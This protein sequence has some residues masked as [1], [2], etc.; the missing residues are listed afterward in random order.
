M[1]KVHSDEKAKQ[2]ISGFSIYTESIGDF[3]DGH[4]DK[5][6]RFLLLVK[7]SQPE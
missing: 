4:P 6:S 1:S 7:H 5:G 3:R 2:R